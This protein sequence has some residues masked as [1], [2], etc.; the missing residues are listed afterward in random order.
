LIA[1]VEAK[2]VEKEQKKAYAAQRRRSSGTPPRKVTPQKANGQTPRKQQHSNKKKT[3][4]QEAQDLANAIKASKKEDEDTEQRDKEF[5]AQINAAI[6]ASSKSE[7]RPYSTVS[8]VNAVMST[9]E[10]L[11][12]EVS[13]IVRPDNPAF[14]PEAA[15]RL[16]ADT[17]ADKPNLPA[18]QSRISLVWRAG[19]MEGD[20]HSEKGAWRTKTPRDGCL[21]PT[22]RIPSPPDLS[23][24]AH[25]ITRSFDPTLYYV[26]DTVVDVG[27][28]T[29][30]TDKNMYEQRRALQTFI[31]GIAAEPDQKKDT[32]DELAHRRKVCN[33]VGF[34]YDLPGNREQLRRRARIYGGKGAV[35]DDFAMWF[36]IWKNAEVQECRYAHPRRRDPTAYTTGNQDRL[37]GLLISTMLRQWWPDGVAKRAWPY[38][39]YDPNKHHQATYV[40]YQQRSISEKSELIH[41]AETLLPAPSMLLNSVMN[42]GFSLMNCELTPVY[43]EAHPTA[44]F[45]PCHQLLYHNP[46]DQNADWTRAQRFDAGKLCH[47]RAGDVLKLR[48]DVIEGVA[49]QEYLVVLTWHKLIK[50]GMLQAKRAVEALLAKA[51]EDKNVGLTATLE[52]T[53][54]GW[55][56]LEEHCNSE[57]LPGLLQ[58][59]VTLYKL[60][61]K[62]S[63]D[64]KWTM[65]ELK[66]HM[67]ERDSANRPFAADQ[68]INASWDD[69]D[70]EKECPKEYHPAADK[71]GAEAFVWMHASENCTAAEQQKA[72]EAKKAGSRGMIAHPIGLH[73]E[74]LKFTEAWVKASVQCLMYG[75]Q[76]AYTHELSEEDGSRENAKRSVTQD[77][78]AFIRW[79]ADEESK[80]KYD[81]AG[82]RKLRACWDSA[83]LTSLNRLLDGCFPVENPANK[84]KGADDHSLADVYLEE[85][86]LQQDEG[87]EDYEANSS[88]REKSAASLSWLRFEKDGIEKKDPAHKDVWLVPDPR[89]AVGKDGKAWVAKNYEVFDDWMGK[90]GWTNYA[91]SKKDYGGIMVRQLKGLMNKKEM[92]PDHRWAPI[93]QAA[94]KAYPDT[95]WAVKSLVSAICQYLLLH[96]PQALLLTSL[97]CERDIEKFLF[98]DANRWRSKYPFTRCA[99]PDKNDLFKQEAPIDEAMK[100][101]GE[102]R[103]LRDL[104]KSDTKQLDPANP[105]KSP[106]VFNLLDKRS[107]PILTPHQRRSSRA[108]SLSAS[109]TSNE[110]KRK[111]GKDED[112]NEEEED[113]GSES[114]E[115]EDARTKKAAKLKVKDDVAAAKKDNRERE[116]EQRAKEAKIKNFKD[117]QEADRVQKAKL[118]EISRQAARE[119]RDNAVQHHEHILVHMKDSNDELKQSAADCHKNNITPPQIDD[120]PLSLPKKHKTSPMKEMKEEVKRAVQEGLQ[121]FYLHFQQIFGPGAAPANPLGASAFGASA[122]PALPPVQLAPSPAPA[123]AAGHA[124]HSTQAPPQ[125]FHHYASQP[126]F[127]P[128]HFSAYP[129]IA[130]PGPE[131]WAHAPINDG[132]RVAG[133]IESEAEARMRAEH[134]RLVRQLGMAQMDSYNQ[135][136]AHSFRQGMAVSAA[137]QLHPTR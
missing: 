136:A 44:F 14:D 76:G 53:L 35:T 120:A 51:T 106:T 130:P 26:A 126:A 88:A 112:E 110:R 31:E 102:K 40:F 135:V 64:S 23:C 58:P 128:Q 68:F 41:H 95:K 100:P 71:T 137:A 85:L 13:F 81:V 67:A 43:Y 86:E 109:M 21:Y 83:S 2:K 103:K 16:I 89:G 59:M 133:W 119:R 72:I 56:A 134:A 49:D 29:F 30:N 117:A 55:A 125:V 114:H 80:T 20:D 4:E 129:S 79:L 90:H 61:S 57:G 121:P 62:A 50:D 45:A 8:K 99:A 47:I 75:G 28:Q 1:K 70:S 131:Y 118:M 101:H 115:E 7:L 3:T 66:A 65:E 18:Y 6:E 63:K 87:E 108:A 5:Q 69:L 132:F 37:N 10:V 33:I 34:N 94:A 96:D 36:A 77:Y 116:R 38:E 60:P 98:R 22:W 122:A 84:K 24:M 93:T 127:Y 113:E 17:S 74:F 104:A 39:S 25:S 54:Q 124:H 46:I 48:A 52:K 15:A 82:L 111:R 107:G 78:H 123:P 12:K 92:A 9:A 105:V 11:L 32:K 91:Y 97:T 73:P 27:A 19:L 42:P